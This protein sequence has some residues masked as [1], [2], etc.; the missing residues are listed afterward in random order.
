[1][2]Q[3]DVPSRCTRCGRLVHRPSNVRV[4]TRV[5]CDADAKPRSNSSTRRLQANHFKGNLSVGLKGEV[6][7]QMVKNEFEC[8][9]VA[10]FNQPDI[11]QFTEA[12]DATHG[13]YEHRSG[14]ATLRR[15]IDLV[16]YAA[17]AG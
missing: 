10:R 11:V 15:D 9:H 1:M 4:M 16:P 6:R 2:R 12:V 13:I 3:Q 8:I 17:R 14:H 7:F 5:W